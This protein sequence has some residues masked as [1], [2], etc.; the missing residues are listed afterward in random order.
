[1]SS[2]LLVNGLP[3]WILAVPLIVGVISYIQ[4]PRL[5]DHVPP[6]RREDRRNIAGEAYIQSGDTAI[7]RG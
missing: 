4:T 5:G 6:D 1:M 7:S 2:S 3:F